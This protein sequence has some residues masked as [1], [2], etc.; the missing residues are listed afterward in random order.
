MLSNGEV[1]IYAIV[2][3]LASSIAS[4]GG[5]ILLLV[6]EHRIRPLL[7]A[8]TAFAA[9]VLL[10]TAF[11]DLL[12]EGAAALG[13]AAFELAMAGFLAFYVLEQ[14]VR[15]VHSHGR[16][17][18]ADQPSTAL[19]LTGDTI[20]NFVDG[21]VIAAAFMVNTPTGVATAIAVAVH[22]VPQEIGDFAILLHNGVRPKLVLLLNLWSAMAAVLGAVTALLFGQTAAGPALVAMTA[23]FFIYIAASDLVP[24]IH[25]SENRTTTVWFFAGIAAVWLLIRAM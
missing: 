14:I 9:G 5:G 12:P 20:H 10:A 4:L 22:E 15:S 11:L 24:E 8:L 23:G 25:R 19:V 18:L 13:G 1:A 21:A 2:A 6:R 3:T 7:P 17:A 16:P